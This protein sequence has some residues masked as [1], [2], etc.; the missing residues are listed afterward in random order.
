VP[1]SSSAWTR[2]RPARKGAG[3]EADDPVSRLALAPDSLDLA[4]LFRVEHRDRGVA[5]RLAGVSY[6]RDDRRPAVIHYLQVGLIIYF[7]GLTV[8]ALLMAIGIV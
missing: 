3:H 8:T 2:R 7:G 6:R 1:G 4:G 5:C